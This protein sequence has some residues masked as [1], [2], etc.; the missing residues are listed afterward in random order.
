MKV[1]S[2][3]SSKK[4]KL[5]NKD[6]IESLVMTADALKSDVQQSKTMPFK[7]G[8]TQNRDTFVD[9]TDKTKGQVRIVTSNPYARRLYFHPEYK[10]SKNVNSKAGGMWFDPYID[11]AKKNFAK[12][13]FSK[14]M[15]NKTK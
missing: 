12:K 1:T 15:R 8:S 10:F 5:L 2:K 7:T 3:V 13:T 11:G 14:I 6:I 4:L 9:N